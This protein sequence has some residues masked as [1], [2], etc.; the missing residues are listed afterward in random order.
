MRFYFLVS[1]RNIWRH[2]RRTLITALA[3]AISLGLCMPLIT[4]NDGF[5]LQFYDVLVKQR[6][7]H[8]QLRHP[9]YAKTKIMHDTMHNGTQ[10]QQQIDTH[11]AT[12]V[13]TAR[14]F[15]NALVSKEETASGAN[16]TGV[17]P[18]SEANLT[19]MDTAIETG[20]Y[21]SET[22]NLEIVIGTEL[23]RE[24]E[25][26]V[27]DIL[28]VYTQAAD[29][30]PAYELYTVVGVYSSG[31]VMMDRGMQMHLTDLQNLLQLPEQLH[32]VIAL[33]DTKDRSVIGDY[34]EALPDH[35]NSGDNG[36]TFYRTAPDGFVSEQSSPPDN[37][38]LIQSWWESSPQT[39][40]LMGFRDVATGLFL[41]IIFFIAGFGV[42]N[43]MLMS[44][45]E[46]TRELGL[47]KAVG[48]RPVKLIW[49]VLVEAGLLGVISAIVGI[50][51]GASLNWYLVN[52]GIDI[53][54]GSGEPMKMMGASF[55]PVV[56]GDVD[57]GYQIQ[58]VLAM[59]VFS[60]VAAIWPAIRAARLEP[61]KSL[62]QD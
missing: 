56:F 32:E 30:T 53:S 22:A 18:T 61:V 35:V 14:L 3:M 50:L 54:G 16:I 55:D 59:I 6:L 51:I 31:S 52:H 8:V 25:A 19:R 46:R 62:R 5:Y 34:V 10:L 45:F 20:R 39:S 4:L 27:E 26:S 23:A 9:D 11:P 40:E 58:P 17:Q 47:L 28:F 42:L 12:A 37:P 43:T 60:V 2:K 33:T 24:L 49:L 44:V 36:Y 13:S 38:V 29:G 57:I 7:G 1:W 15:G 48:L 21:L 41:G